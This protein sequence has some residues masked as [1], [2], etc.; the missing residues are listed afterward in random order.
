MKKVA[1]LLIL[2][3]SGLAAFGI[4]GLSGEITTNTRGAA[5]GM[6]DK[7][8]GSLDWSLNDRLKIVVGVLSLVGG[9]ILRKD[10]K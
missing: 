2:F 9:L 10:S 1:V 5:F 3:G 7:L 4:T 8:E 6:P